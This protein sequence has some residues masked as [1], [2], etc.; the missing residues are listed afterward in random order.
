MVTIERLE[1]ATYSTQNGTIPLHEVA[2]ATKRMPDEMV[3]PG[4]VTEAFLH[5]AQPLVGELPIYAD[6]ESLEERGE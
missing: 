2:N 4:G 1:S 5:Y 6:L 3:A